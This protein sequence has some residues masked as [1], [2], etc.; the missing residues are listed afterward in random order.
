MKKKLNVK[1]DCSGMFSEEIIET[2]LE[3]RGVKDP[4]HFLNPTAKDILPYEAMYKIT[5]AAKIVC[6]GI[7]NGKKFYVNIDSDT[8]GVSSGAI[9]VRYLRALGCNVDWHVSIGKTHGTSD[10]L[11][12]KLETSKPDILIIV[13]S[14]DSDITNYIKIK[15]MG[16]KTIVLDHHIVEPEIPYDD[17]VCLVSSNRY[18]PNPELS[19][20]GT[21]WKFVKYLD[22]ILGT[23]EAD[24]LIDLA[25]CG[26]VSDMMDM[27]DK[28]MENR[29]LVSFG[30]QNLQNPA[31]K[32]IIGG[33][34]YNS[35]SYSYSVAPLINASC[36]YNKNE[37]AVKAFLADDN[38][39]VLK[40]IRVLKDCKDKQTEEIADMMPDVIQQAEEQLDKKM[41]VIIIETDS[42]IYGLLANQMLSK[43]K[44]PIMVLKEGYAGYS[45]SCRSI[46][47][48]NFK[49]ICD[50][51]GL[52]L[53]GGHEEA[54]GVVNIYYND[55]DA[56]REAIETK[57]SNIEFE[58]EVDIDVSLELGDISK[59]LVAKLKELDK[60]S[61]N[62][63]KPIRGLIRVDNYEASTM[64][65]GK[66]LVVS[67][68][69]WFKFIK[70]NSGESMLEEMEDHA[71]FGD[72]LGFVGTFDMGFLGRD[73]SIRMIVD[74]IVAD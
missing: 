34:E 50:D 73:F 61:G 51:T 44:R 31:M 54:F 3:S 63:F 35:N 12:D 47:C 52:G 5:D 49:A 1:N 45:G 18:Y 10:E 17:Y 55:F 71:M 20:S 4:E 19:G 65:K 15:N 43:Y 29:A 40:Y 60:I 6:D 16:I 48:G 22:L 24:D 30:L 9:I 13:D 8:D 25:A 11:L 70:W 27:S 62:G 42:G 33:Y 41:I 69:S 68:N 32:K 7:S 56:F 39:E 66:H 36:R 72:E 21:V 23:I 74:D 38:K 53:F 64:S 67:P 59:D 37:D 2:I 46:G 26:I 28:H 57:L 14:L 58:T